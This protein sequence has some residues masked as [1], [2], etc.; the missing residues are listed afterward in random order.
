MDTD[1]VRQLIEF[2]LNT[3]LDLFRDAYGI[4]KESVV[5]TPELKVKFFQTV[6][7]YEKFISDF[8]D[9]YN[10]PTEGKENGR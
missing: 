3:T 8:L 9:E 10:K 4:Q 1:S 7:I 2:G 6:L 5:L